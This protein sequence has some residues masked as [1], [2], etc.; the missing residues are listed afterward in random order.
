MGR[1]S[2]PWDPRDNVGGSALWDIWGS[3][4]GL[5]PDGCWVWLGDGQP[6][7]TLGMGGGSHLMV[8]ADPV[9]TVWGCSA[10]WL[11]GD[12]SGEFG[13]VRV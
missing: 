11:W 2:A 6:C 10:P 12:P 9:G 7:G 1:H 3:L 5:S 4:G 8:S 13:G